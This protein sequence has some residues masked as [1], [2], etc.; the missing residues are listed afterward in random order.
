MA[1]L[2][3]AG[4]GAV[5]SHTS[6]ARRLGLDVPRDEAVQMTI[7]AA[8]KAKVRGAKVWRSRTLSPSDITTRGRCRVTNL[9]RTLIDLAGV[10]DAGWLRA[11]FDSAVRQNAAN[12]SWITRVLWRHGPGR[13]GIGRL[14]A[15]VEEY[16]RG[17]EVPDSA[18]ESIGLELAKATGHEPRLHYNVL[19]GTRRVAEV[20]LAW[21]EQKLCV[22]FDGWEY[23]GTREGFV[24]DRARDRA[25]VPLGWSVLRFPWHEVVREPDAFIEEVVRVYE[26]RA[27]LGKP[28][29]LAKRGAKA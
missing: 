26:S 1:A 23:H 25:L 29:A 6:A 27:A 2:L 28:P 11:A 19:D 7:P 21:P 5:L 13:R 20:D 15:L 4:E 12:V 17:G 10:L 24:S 22:E 16:R 3:A 18:L 8:R 9:P 14:R